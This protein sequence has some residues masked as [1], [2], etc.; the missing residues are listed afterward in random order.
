MSQ[1]KIKEAFQSPDLLQNC[2]GFLREYA[3][4]K[5]ARAACAVVSLK[6]I[7]FPQVSQVL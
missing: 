3:S 1:V 2:T 6:D 5:S 4:E 7:A